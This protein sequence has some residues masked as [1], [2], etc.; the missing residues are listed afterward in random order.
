MTEDETGPL[1][2]PPAAPQPTG[3]PTGTAAHRRPGRV[4]AVVLA[5]A[6]LVTATL[7][8]TTDR[9]AGR[10][11]RLGGLVRTED[12]PVGHV[13]GPVEYPGYPARPPVGGEHSALPQTCAVYD[14]PVPA[15]HVVH[16]LEHGAVWVTYRPDLDDDGVEVLRRQVEG[17]AHRLLSPLPGQQ[18][19]VVLTSWGVQ[20]EL[21]DADDPRVEA[22]LQAYTRNPGAPEPGA[23]CQ[24]NERTGRFPFDRADLPETTQA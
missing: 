9:Q 10:S 3:T 5:L 19:P 7:V 15:E 14:E 4:V 17:R 20:L 22:F 13:A 8:A 24:G 23:P 11:E 12:L 16:S 18:A 21:A 2:D 6:A 1:S